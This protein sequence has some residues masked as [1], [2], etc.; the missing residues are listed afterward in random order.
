MKKQIGKTILVLVIYIL[1]SV[2]NY[3]YAKSMILINEKRDWTKK[4]RTFVIIMSCYSWVGVVAVGC[5]HATKNISNDEK[6][7]W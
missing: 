3:N 4:D 6:A 2:V 7:D 5:I 1:G